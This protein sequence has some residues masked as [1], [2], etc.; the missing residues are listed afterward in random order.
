[1]AE[2]LRSVSRDGADDSVLMRVLDEVGDRVQA[3]LPVDVEAYAQAH[4]EHAERLRQLLPAVHLMA[5]LGRS[6]A[7]GEASVP[8]AVTEAEPVAGT[9]GDFRIVRPVGRGGMGVVFEAEQVSLGR[10]VALKVLPLAATLDPRRLE[11]FQNE[12]R[13]AACLHHSHIVPVHYVGCER[14]IHFYAMQF[15]EGLSLAD[16]LA[17]LRRSTGTEPPSAPAEAVTG[18][19]RPGVAGGAGPATTLPRAG[20]TTQAPGRAP[21]HCRRVAG[22]GA[23]AAAALDYAHQVGVV[24]RDVKPANLLVDARGDVWVTDF[25]LAQF[26]QGEGNLTLTGDLVGTLRYMSP[27]QALAKRV[28]IDHRT[29]VYSLG[30]TLYELLTLQPVFGGGDRQ[31]L[32]R[33][34]AF[35]EPRPPR[36]LNKAMPAELETIV[37]KALEKNPADRYATAQELAD[38]LTRFLKDE[39]IRARRPTL[40]Q[41]ARKWSRRHKPV[42]WS[43]AALSLLFL[44][45]AGGAGLWWAQKQAEAAGEARAALREAAGLVEEE[46]WPEGLSAA[47]RAEGIL[48]GA[49]AGGDLRRQ[50]AELIRDF[51]MA[52]RLQEARLKGTGVKDGHFDF[53]AIDAAYAAAFREYGLDVDGLDA[54]AAAEQ[55]HS[56]AIYPQLLVALD[57]WALIRKNLKRP[58]W[59]RRLAVARLADPNPW[60]NR[61]RDALEGKDPRALEEAIAAGV[62]DNWLVSTVELLGVLAEGTSSHGRVAVALARAQQRH[63]GDFWINESLGLFLMSAR[64]PRPREAVRYFTVA[65]ALRPQSPGAHYNLGIALKDQGRLDEAIAAYRAAIRLEKNDPQVHYR[66]GNALGRKGEFNEAIAAYRAAIRVKPDYPEAHTKLGYALMKQDKPHEA[67]AEYRAAL[68]SKKPFPQAYLAHNGLGNALWQERQDGEAFAEYREAIRLKSDYASAHSNLC[69]ALRAKGRLGEAIAEGQVAIRLEKNDPEAHYNLGV[70]LG[71][72]GRVDEAIA[73]YREAI[74]LKPDYP[75][76]H[77]NFR[78]A[79]E[80]KGL[81]DEALREYRKA[82][83]SKV[84]FPEAYAD[85]YRLA[86][87]L[88]D[89]R[90]RDEAIAEYRAAIRLKA[91]GP[92]AYY[93]LAHALRHNGQLDEAIAQYRAA[94]RLKPDYPQAHTALGAALE[95]KGLRDEA[96]REYHQALLSKVLFPEAYAVFYRFAK[97][98]GDK[99]RRDEA[100]AEYRAAIRLKADTPGGHT[101][102]GA[103]LEGRGLLDEATAQYR[104]AIR[105]KADTPGAH[106]ALGAALERKGLR[107]EALRE[108]RQALLS[109]VFLPAAYADFYRLARALGDK[110]RRDEAIAEYRAAIRLKADTPDAH[111]YLGAALER[112][113]LLDEAIA[114]YRAALASKGPSSSPQGAH[115]G[116]ANALRRNGQLDEAIAEYR[117]A[118]R[119]MPRLASRAA[120]AHTAL[121]AALERKGLRDEALREYRQALLSKVFFPEPYADFYRLAKALGDK[122]RRDEAI[123]EYRA[124]IRLKADTPD[125]H[126]YLG[127]ALERKGLLDE[128]IAQYRAAVQFQKDYAPAHFSLALALDR[129][130]Q[131]D[132]A[133]AEYRH[134]L[135]I[136][137]DYPEAHTNLGN[138]L[139]DKGKPGAAAEYRAALRSKQP[140][141]EA[142]KA[143]TGLGN[144][145]SRKGQFGEA[146]TEYRKA[147]RINKNFAPAHMALGFL[148]T[149]KRELEKAI[150]EFREAIRNKK[151]WPEAHY[152][153]GITLQ[154]KGRLAEAIAAYREAVRLN[155]KVAAFHNTLA[156]L[157][158]TCPNPKLRDHPQA[159]QSAKRAVRLWPGNGTFWNTLGVAL[160]RTGTWK[161]AVAAL[162]KSM[163]LSKGGNSFDW[164]VLAMAYRQLGE[165]QKARRW[166]DEAVQWME[167]NQPKDEELRRFRRE[168]AELLRVDKKSD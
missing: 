6:A 151:D 50:A 23:Q 127:A 69:A 164:F 71:D 119:L 147:I 163:A 53:E 77:T 158:A 18:A 15:I 117:A 142:Y 91:D 124:A 168:A 135:R 62:A 149:K 140:F 113:G 162:E 1:M 100:I 99:R 105:L 19:Y 4:P 107:D 103:A 78:A 30:A 76:A 150:A 68:V 83:L 75:E 74:R 95:R 129:K 94:I 156:W 72:K 97:G 44:V 101:A 26:R 111:T 82:L 65:V 39:P 5:N 98:L 161:E 92:E 90:R 159:V 86:N 31:E 85:F 46:R 157:L 121:G 25:G 43:V 13:A 42:V 125:A 102:L 67:I 80:G 120:E 36:R 22:L 51:K 52:Q 131:R 64:P 3:G 167:K 144:A 33:Q 114:Q 126:T 118:I 63:P 41:R 47:R 7:A 56:R 73:E 133:M 12:A 9:L 55:I 134:A 128:A 2:S 37:L 132:E 89:K 24:H 17:Q 48:G 96:L 152:N 61:L 106:T 104:A 40:V 166:Y 112:K 38:D 139:L 8:P 84:F 11:R 123:A 14:G 153:L 20:L 45:L 27:E 54:A 116:L 115:Y 141:P 148:L 29:D 165:K 155:P 34:I 110:R 93:G 136:Q 130:G 59:G 146:V 87:A 60:R 143:H 109:K 70:A 122:R 32:L 145:L 138:C 88:G 58:D 57:R 160:Y 21:A 28:P 108:Y 10:R 79:L 35:E 66:L 16:L 81:L 154:L 137:P 49:G